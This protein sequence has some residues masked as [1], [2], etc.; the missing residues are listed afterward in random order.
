M[1]GVGVTVDTI[2][3]WAGARVVGCRTLVLR[4]VCIDSRQ[5]QRQALFVA[6]PGTNTDGHAYVAEVLAHGSVA[7][8][9]SKK[10]YRTHRAILCA[11][12][13]NMHTDAEANENQHTPAV[14][15]AMDTMHTDVEANTAGVGI[16][17]PRTDIDVPRTDI[18]VPRTDIDVPRTDID[19]PRTDIDVPRTDIDVPRTDMGTN[20]HEADE[21]ITT[22]RTET[23]RRYA[24]M[25]SILVVADPL[26]ALLR[27][28]HKYL[29]Q[30]PPFCKIAITGS[31]GKTTTKEL[32]AGIIG[33]TRDVY[34]TNA[35]QNSAIGIPLSILR[36][37]RVYRYLLV[38]VG[39]GYTGEIA[40][41]TRMLNP[42]IVLITNIGHAHIEIFKSRHAIA[43]EKLALASESNALRAWY[44]HSRDH[45][46]FRCPKWMYKL[47]RHYDTEV[48]AKRVSYVPQVNSNK[49]LVALNGHS[50]HTALRGAF[51]YDNVRAVIAVANKIEIPDNEIIAG[52]AQ[53]K[54][55]FGRMQIISG[56]VTI[57]SDCYNA[58]PESTLGALDFLR[59]MHCTGKKICVIGAMKELGQ[60]SMYFHNKV[61]VRAVAMQF[62]YLFFIGVEF[63]H[64]D[65]NSYSGVHY[66]VDVDCAYSKIQAVVASQDVVLLKGSR[67]MQLEN[68]IP[69]IKCIKEH[70]NVL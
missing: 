12:M 9:V 65:V 49:S 67:S 40:S 43:Q 56:D 46:F 42:H 66:F 64:M 34:Y 31:N 17:V 57:I 69:H 68:I 19:V 58:N 70:A 45:H 55:L 10:Y 13:E 38:E 41:I 33:Q 62:T 11:G 14:P 2:A 37:D 5:I 50:A 47:C 21:R 52:I 27:I 8:L 48:L 39:T 22:V 1:I 7:V 44:I 24:G 53:Y 61:F 32:L 20:V 6:L 26:H 30:F 35:N 25:Q 63:S 28:A 15:P 4:H 54:P 23:D 36:I 59:D 60:R 18:D 3:Q 51:Q 16:D 29:E